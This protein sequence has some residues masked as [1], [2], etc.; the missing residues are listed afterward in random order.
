MAFQW[1]RSG[2]HYQERNCGP[3]LQIPEGST[4]YSHLSAF[5]NKPG[6][7]SDLP[8]SVAVKLSDIVDKERSAFQKKKS[9]NPT[10]DQKWVT[11]IIKAG[12]LSDKVAA[13]A[14]VVQESPPHALEA[15]DQLVAMA[16]KKEQRTSMLALDALK[17]LLIH[18]LL[19]DRHLIPRS[20]RPWTDS[21]VT[22]P[23]AILFWYEDQLISRVERIIE[24]IE[25]GLKSSLEHFKK[26]AM[27]I[28]ADLL[29]SKPEKEGRLLTDLVNKLGD[30]SKSICSKCMDLMKNVIRVHPTMKSVM[31][32]E[33]RQLVCKPNLPIRVIHVAIMLIS[34]IRLVPGDHDVA[35][36]CVEY[37]VSL[38]EKAVKQGEMGSRLLSALLNGINRAFPFLKSAEPLAKHIDSLFKIAHT[39]AFTT[40][41]Q[42]L[43][44]I[45]LIAIGGDSSSGGRG[46]GKEGKGKGKGKGKKGNKRDNRITSETES[47]TKEDIR[48]KTDLVNRYYRALYAKLFTD[49]VASRQRNTVFLNLLYRSMKVDPSEQR[50]SAFFV[51]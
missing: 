12:T 7:V 35:A 33:V 40:S 45:S 18:N 1:L 28:V 25:V 5:E 32:R 41:T 26:H 36:Q 14:L 38:F 46:E 47:L 51:V 8:A 21:R 31:V 48:S 24:A 4:W 30:P 43:T 6:E 49:Q 16:L 11:E 50:F 39:A 15:L 44:L 29:V 42:A 10:G 23:I 27:E 20:R 13:L 17:D 37:Y 2:S 9:S 3:I 22:L 19:P 34:Q